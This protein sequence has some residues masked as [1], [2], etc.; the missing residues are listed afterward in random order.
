M[1]AV[2]TLRWSGARRRCGDSADTRLKVV[3]FLVQDRL[4][5]NG[6]VYRLDANWQ[7]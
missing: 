7:S 1:L 3:P 2:L 4:V 6:G 5:E